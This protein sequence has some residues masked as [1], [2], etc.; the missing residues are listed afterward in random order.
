NC[1][2]A[3]S[4]GTLIVKEP[5]ALVIV[6][7]CVPFNFTLTPGSVSPVPSFTTPVILTF[8]A[9]AVDCMNII[10][11][12]MKASFISTKQDSDQA[13]LGL[14]NRVKICFILNLN[15]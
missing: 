1:K 9:K 11:N 7:V 3:F 14:S 12:H 6:P 8:C 13:N 2:T 5:D 10:K 15:K 4:L